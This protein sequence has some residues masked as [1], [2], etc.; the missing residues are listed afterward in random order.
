MCCPRDC[1]SRHNGAAAV[2]PFC[3]ET[4][5]LGQQMLNATEAGA[6]TCTIAASWL[7]TWPKARNVFCLPKFSCAKWPTASC[8]HCYAFYLCI[9][10]HFTVIYAVW[11]NIISNT[12]RYK[13]IHENLKSLEKLFIW[14]ASFP[15]VIFSPKISRSL[16][17]IFTVTHFGYE[18]II[19]RISTD[20]NILL[21]EIWKSSLTNHQ[22]YKKR[23]PLRK[24]SC[25]GMLQE[26]LECSD[27]QKEHILP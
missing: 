8:F 27:D 6:D 21:M 25:H 4:Q 3:R 10:T 12:Y 7:L 24:I 9:H 1:V 11:M 13:Y 2:P 17:D 22:M 26:M 18:W 23:I 14:K 5:S 19:F 20:T 16:R 15:R